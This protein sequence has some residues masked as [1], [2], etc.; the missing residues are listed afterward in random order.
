MSDTKEETMADATATVTKP[1]RQIYCRADQK[2][3]DVGKKISMAALPDSNL[4]FPV[5]VFATRNTAVNMAVKAAA[6][7]TAR[8][9]EIDETEIVCVPSFR[10]NR[11]EVSLYL[12][13]L[14]EMTPVPAKN[15]DA[16]MELKVGS[17]TDIKVLAGAIAN[18]AREVKSTTLQAIGQDA[19][20]QAIRAVAV[21]REY[22][23]GQPA[24]GMDIYCDIEFTMVQVGK[25]TEQTTALKITCLLNKEKID[26]QSPDPPVR[27]NNTSGEKEEDKEESE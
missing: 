1:G 13:K 14:E 6:I 25:R 5:Y 22:L 7:A 15:S 9:R 23:I 18:S 10:E 4:G 17:K 3:P 19:V 2:A 16:P 24:D 20:F 8:L 12:S 21:A 26:D 27:S 11:N